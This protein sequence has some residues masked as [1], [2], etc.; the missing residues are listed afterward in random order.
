MVTPTLPLI[1]IFFYSLI[2]SNVTSN[3]VRRL[4]PL[5]HLF[6]YFSLYILISHYAL[7]VLNLARFLVVLREC[8]VGKGI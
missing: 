4:S 5:Q 2:Q 3:K 8:A 6:T 1:A 7:S